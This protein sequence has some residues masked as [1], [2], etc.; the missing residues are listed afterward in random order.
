MNKKQST[1]TLTDLKNKIGEVLAV[2][3]QHGSV[4]ITS[5]GRVKY[6]IR[7]VFGEEGATSLRQ[8][9]K[10]K[11]TT[12][13]VEIS[14]DLPVEETQIVAPQAEAV[15]P[16]VAEPSPEPAPT[17]LSAMEALAAGIF[18]KREEKDPEPEPETTPVAPVETPVAAPEPA[19]VAPK[20]L[21]TPTALLPEMQSWNRNSNK[22]QAWA[23]RAR[24]LVLNN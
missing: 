19:P 15:K 3:D 20:N 18:G 2:A 17:T 23:E 24:K 13:P 9:I 7:R 4:Q 10:K 21:W 6:E 8:A 12:K 5:Y 11:K 16:V 14:A 22:E 1:A